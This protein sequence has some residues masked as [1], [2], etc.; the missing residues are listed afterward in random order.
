MIF[1]PFCVKL[2]HPLIWIPIRAP[3]TSVANPRCLSRIRFKDSKKL[4]LAHV[5]MIRV[6]H[7]GFGSWVFTHP[8]SRGKKGTGSRIWIRNTATDPVDSRF[9]EVLWRFSPLWACVINVLFVEVKQSIFVK[10]SLIGATYVLFTRKTKFTLNNFSYNGRLRKIVSSLGYTKTKKFP[11][12]IRWSM[13]RLRQWSLSWLGTRG[14]PWPLALGWKTE[15]GNM[16][17][18]FRKIYGG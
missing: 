9:E 2:L 8:G 17:W 10:R 4:F 6:V 13:I 7:P 16:C 1:R 11:Y 18:N 3:H 14:I 5:N 12:S 15:H